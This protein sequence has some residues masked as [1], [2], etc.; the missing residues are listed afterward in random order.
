MIER[1]HRDWEFVSRWD[2]SSISADMDDGHG[3]SWF[4]A[5]FCGDEKKEVS[6]DADAPCII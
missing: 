4:V 1:R 6:S 3:I 2:H 5:K